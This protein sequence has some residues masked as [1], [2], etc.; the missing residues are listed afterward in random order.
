MLHWEPALTLW[1]DARSG[2]AAHA[3]AGVGG[4]RATSLASRRR[5]CAIAASVNSSCA[6]R[7]PRSRRRPSPGCAR[8]AR[9][10]SRHVFGRDAIAQ[11][12]RGRPEFASTAP[13]GRR[14]AA[15]ANSSAARWRHPG[16]HPPFV[17]SVRWGRFSALQS[18]PAFG[19]PSTTETHGSKYGRAGRGGRKPFI[20]NI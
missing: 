17:C 13:P 1:P 16:R 11:P 12:T 10:A 3:A 14:R 20:I 19:F 18:G 7:G 15:R 2:Y 8:G 9:T 4:G 6:P 5:F